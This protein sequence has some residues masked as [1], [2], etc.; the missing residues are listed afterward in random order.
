MDIT[1]YKIR[2]KTTVKKYHDNISK[3]E[4][5]HGLFSKYERVGTY[6]QYSTRSNVVIESREPKAARE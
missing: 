4:H 5:I 1:P 6:D 3:K 2:R